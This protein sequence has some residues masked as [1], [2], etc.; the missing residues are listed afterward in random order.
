MDKPTPTTVHARMSIAPGVDF[1]VDKHGN[2]TIGNGEA[3]RM[4][5]M[6]KEANGVIETPRNQERG[7]DN[8]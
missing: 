7:F 2:H 6:N 3:R 8:G 1:A 5:L 4:T